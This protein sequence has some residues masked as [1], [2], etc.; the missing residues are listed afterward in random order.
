[1][2]YDCELSEGPRAMSVAQRTTCM[3]GVVSLWR[4]CLGGVSV[5]DLWYG[6][7]GE[8]LYQ[9]W[10][11]LD[12]LVS[13]LFSYDSRRVLVLDGRPTRTRPR[14]LVR[15]L[16]CAVWVFLTVPPPVHILYYRCSRRREEHF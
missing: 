14:T 15:G 9:G 7:Q 11:C 2:A 4:R 3:M 6:H 13:T 1:M 10:I 12:F 5:F 8:G 16:A